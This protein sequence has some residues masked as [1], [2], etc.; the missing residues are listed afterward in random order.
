MSGIHHESISNR[1]PLT[2]LIDVD[3]HVGFAISVN[4]EE[5]VIL[6][7]DYW[8][9]MVGGLPMNSFVLA[10]AFYSG[11][12]AE[13]PKIDREVLLLRVMGPADMPMDRT[14][15]DA[16]IDSYTKRT[17]VERARQSG[18]D[19]FEF[20]EYDGFDK[21]THTELQFGAIRCRIVGSFYLK[22]SNLMLG[23][24]IE[25][26]ASASH[27]R[28]YKPTS[29]ALTTIVNF[30]D[31]IRRKQAE[32]KAA[33]LGFNEV[34]SPFKLGSVRY[35]STDRM[36]RGEGEALVSVGV[37]PIDF[38][39][40]R[41]AVFGMTRT[42]KSNMIKTLSSAVGVAGKSNNVKIGQCIFDINGEY[43]NANKQ[44]EG[45]SIAD[46]FGEDVVCYRSTKPP[47]SGFRD[48]RNNFFQE[49]QIGLS[50]IQ[51]Q[52]RQT[53][54]LSNDMQILA[55]SMSLEEPAAEEATE[56]DINR[57][58]RQVEAFKV[59]LYSVGFESPRAVNISLVPSQPVMRQVFSVMHPSLVDQ[60]VKKE[61]KNLNQDEVFALAQSHYGDLSKPSTLRAAKDFILDA[62]EADRRIQRE[63]DPQ[64]PKTGVYG[65]RL[66]SSNNSD[67]WFDDTLKALANLI[68]HKND[69]G[70][71]IKCKSYLGPL[72]ELHSVSGSG[73]VEADIY[74]LLSDG[75]I[76]IIDLSVGSSAIREAI[77]ERIARE[78]FMRSMGIFHQGQASPNIVLYVEE[79][80]NLIGRDAKPDETW[81]RIAK[82]GAKA[83]IS[84]VYATQEPSSVQPNIMANTENWIVTHLNNDD[85]LRVLGK[86]YDFADFSL[87]L[88]RA[89]DVGFARVKTLSSPYV[90]PTQIDLFEPQRIVNKLESLIS[91]ATSNNESSGATTPTGNL[92]SELDQ[93][94][95]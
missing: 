8:K 11:N 37:N 76:V 3:R 95:S 66:R 13:T 86:F 77:S 87:S 35:T 60:A 89:Q 40:R 44:D 56:S 50:I 79:A 63:Y 81:P 5:A 48:I 70:G 51:E 17:Q 65:D 1:N 32:K 83:N 10:S 23:A 67:P 55:T 38:L 93:L 84:L 21:F 46:V 71:Y 61:G 57:W 2:A 34:P 28:A 18:R 7:N 39:A 91:G 68:G 9:E 14:R 74:N 94:L 26:F 33:E 6:S 69:I 80:H 42:G 30:I 31:P 82:E 75:K 15:I 58:K 27:L 4:F 85:E 45:S 49:P 73:E 22:N 43:A 41:T 92:S 72:S 19:T 59:L 90:V 29:Q 78:I 36:H 53:K 52:L 64:K 16:M 25:N 54:N 24:D 47:R 12:Y 20:D 62:R 88:K